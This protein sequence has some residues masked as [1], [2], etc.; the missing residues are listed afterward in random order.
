MC[1]R[2]R[3]AGAKADDRHGLA[4]ERSHHQFADF[5]VGNGLQRYGIDD[6]DH[7]SILP[8]V[9]AI[10]LGAF[11]SD[12]WTI[13]FGKA[14]GVVGLDAKHFFDSQSVLLRVRLGT[15]HQR[16]QLCVLAG[17]ESLFL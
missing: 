14:E 4:V 11:K 1:I 8:D 16:R 12:T 13:H 6:F 9:Q 7:K 17:I 15:N 5:T 3:I 2:D 10:L